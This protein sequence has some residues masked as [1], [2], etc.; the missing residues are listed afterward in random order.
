MLL[1]DSCSWP[2]MI[3]IGKI[4]QNPFK[5]DLSIFEINLLGYGEIIKTVSMVNDIAAG[6]KKYFHCLVFL[7]EH[8]TVLRDRISMPCTLSIYSYLSLRIWKKWRTYMWVCNLC[9]CCDICSILS[10]I[11]DIY[12]SIMWFCI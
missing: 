3:W 12:I 1:V 7:I 4:Q 10:L 11:I 8:T 2:C 5:T 6:V 9:V